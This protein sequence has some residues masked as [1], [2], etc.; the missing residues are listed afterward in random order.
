MKAIVLLLVH[1]LF[2]HSSFAATKITPYLNL[3]NE[4]VMDSLSS[5]LLVS[6]FVL[7]FEDWSEFKEDL[8]DSELSKDEQRRLLLLLQEPVSKTE[9]LF[10]AQDFYKFPIEKSMVRLIHNRDLEFL[11]ADTLNFLFEFMLYGQLHKHLKYIVLN[12]QELSQ[13]LHQD[14]EKDNVFVKY[15]GQSNYVFYSPQNWKLFAPEIK[16]RFIEKYVR[17][18]SL[19][20]YQGVKVE[21]DLNDQNFIKRLFDFM[22]S[23]EM[24]YSLLAR[25]ES[26]SDKSKPVSISELFPVQLSDYLSF[27]SSMGVNCFNCALNF[28][29]TKDKKYIGVSQ[30]TLKKALIENYVLIENQSDIRFGDVVVYIDSAYNIHHAANFVLPDYIYTKN[31]LFRSSDYIIQQFQENLSN[32]TESTERLLTPIYLRHQSHYSAETRIMMNKNERRQRAIENSILA[33]KYTE[34]NKCSDQF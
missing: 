18:P 13:W 22:P 34:P 10:D 20:T 11:K 25:L 19:P 9:Y 6:K 32:Y 30:L 21:I 1:F 2:L 3:P 29:E 4:S 16:K 27:S 5:S 31:G 17:K 23:K 24:L 7:L 28:A 33:P 26:F 12:D 8:A 15:R 14:S